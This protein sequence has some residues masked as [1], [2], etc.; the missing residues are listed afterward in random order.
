MPLVL[1]LALLALSGCDGNRITE[2]HKDLPGGNWYID[3]LASFSFSVTEPAA[4]CNIYYTVRSSE[5]YPFSNLYLTYYLRDSSG[6]LLSTAL[7]DLPMADPV[8]GEPYG[9]GI[10]DLHDLR[11]LALKSVR[12]PYTG[13]Y[14]LQIKQYMRKN[15]LPGVEAVGVRVEKA[16]VNQ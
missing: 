7:H 16:A 2:Q 1:P 13:R 3:S 5:A 8:T 9:E 4:P 6:A 14:V 10:G 15:P 12:F 11:L